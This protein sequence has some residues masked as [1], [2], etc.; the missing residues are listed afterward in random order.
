MKKN[1]LQ[2]KDFNTIEEGKKVLEKLKTKY[3][4]FS[5]IEVLLGLYF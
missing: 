5:N 1:E 4:E 3:P 2:A